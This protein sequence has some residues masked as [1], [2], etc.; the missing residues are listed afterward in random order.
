MTLYLV[1][2]AYHDDP[3]E[4]VMAILRILQHEWY[5]GLHFQD[6]GSFLHQD[7]VVFE[8]K[9]HHVPPL[10]GSVGTSQC[11]YL[12]L[13]H[14]QVVDTVTPTAQQLK[15]TECLEGGGRGRRMDGGEE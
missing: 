13:S 6:L 1:M 8:C 10:E 3:L 9:V 5:E 4:P 7:I 15:G 12:G 14:H 11:H 2:V